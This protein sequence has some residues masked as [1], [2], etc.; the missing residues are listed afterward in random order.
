M[1]EVDDLPLG[2]NYFVLISWKTKYELE[3]SP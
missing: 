3:L 1:N 2:T